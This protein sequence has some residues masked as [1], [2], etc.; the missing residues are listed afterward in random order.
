MTKRDYY[1]VLGVRRDA[2]PAEIK[3][4]YRQAALKFHPDHNPNDKAA[5]ESFKEASEAYEVLTDPQKRQVYDAYGHQGLRGSGFSGVGS[6]EDIF[7]SFGDIFEDFFGGLG[8]GAGR[9]GRRRAQGGADLRED[10]RISFEEVVRGSEREL[11]VVREV[12]CELCRG[13]GIEQGTSRETCRTCGGTGHMNARQGFFMI[14]TTCP[15][16]RGE[17]SV[18][19]HPCADCRGR[20]RVKKKRQLQVKIPAGMED[21]MQLVLRGEGEAGGHGGPPGD[22]YVFV[23]VEP[24]PHFQRAGDDLIAPL[25]LNVAQASLG[26]RLTVPTMYG[27]QEVTVPAGVETGERIRLKGMGV[28]NV[29]SQRKGDHYLEVRVRT[30]K[31][32]SKRQREL[33]ES[34]AKEL[35]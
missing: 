22:L 4:A 14:Q 13:E 6:V 24:H 34:L 27:N 20:G 7:S 2:D 32:L 1:Q 9:G 11:Q 23:H 31:K 33:L 30:P 10:C 19:T 5:E 8:F 12:T 35:S 15:R 3:K 28:P 25:E 17:G 16:C 29:R 18:I 26:T 21:G